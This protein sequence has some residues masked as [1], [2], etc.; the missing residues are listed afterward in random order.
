MLETQKIQENIA[1]KGIK[2]LF[3][4]EQ[5]KKFT[6]DLPAKFY[7]ALIITCV[8]YIKQYGNS[9]LD[10]DYLRNELLNRSGSPFLI[11]ESIDAINPDVPESPRAIDSYSY[12]IAIQNNAKK[13]KG[14][15]KDTPKKELIN[16]TANA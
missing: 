14:S 7:R 8:E 2:E 11:L 16:L 13:G 5:R 1:F 9:F 4:A 3:D 12:K 10:T 15:K 6:M